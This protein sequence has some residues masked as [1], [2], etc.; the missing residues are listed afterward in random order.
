MLYLILGFCPHTLINKTYK[1]SKSLTT[2]YSNH[3][4]SFR[5]FLPDTFLSRHSYYFPKLF[6]YLQLLW[7]IYVF[8]VAPTGLISP[9]PFQPITSR[10]RI[11]VT[12]VRSL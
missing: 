6:L 11:R 12:M 4:S 2:N 9:L 3:S 8:H 1:S 5:S 10:N 7:F